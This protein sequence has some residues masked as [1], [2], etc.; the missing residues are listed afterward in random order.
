MTYKKIN[1]SHRKFLIFAFGGALGALINWSGTYYLT[2]IIHIYYVISNFIACVAAIIF[3]FTYHRFITFKVHDKIGKRFTKFVL[4]STFIIILNV[5]ITYILTSGIGLWYMYS[6]VLATCSVTIVNYILNS[7]YIFFEMNEIRYEERDMDFYDQQTVSKN[8]LRAWFHTSRYEILNSLVHRYY[9]PNKVIMDIGC[10][11]CVWNTDHLPVIGVDI[12]ENM[13]QHAKASGRLSEYKISEISSIDHDDDSVDIIVISEVLEH[14]PD[15]ERTIDEIHR[16]LKPGGI[17]ISSVPYDTLIS[18]WKPLFSIQCIIQ[19]Y[20]FGDDYYKNK[21]GHVQHFSPYIIRNAISAKGFEII[22]KINMKRFT[23]FTVASKI[24]I[25]KQ[26]DD[27][28]V[29]IPTLNESENISKLVDTIEKSYPKISI[30]VADDGS[31]DGTQQIV[32]QKHEQNAK[33]QLLDRSKKPHGLTASIVDAINNVNT[34]YSI[35]IDGDFQ[36]PPEKIRDISSSLKIGNDL[37]IGTRKKVENWGVFRHAISIGATKLGVISL[38]LRRS[39][40]CKDIMSGFFGVRTDLMKEYVEK[41]PS[42]FKG[43]GYKVLFDL[44][45]LLPTDV[46]LAEVPYVFRNREEGHS[47]INKKHMVVYFKSLFK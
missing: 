25:E 42:Y 33:I 11:S 14:L 31:I 35:V 29:I 24:D 47:K 12:N 43:E 13:L 27:T 18:F 8:P 6:A 36:H 10:G 22:E 41:N 21:C 37:A 15:F 5:S 38:R 44:L 2:D 30:I 45:K 34:K 4:V 39:A 23:I 1:V 26:Y 28:T 46:K 20:L 17:M 40:R 7:H 16:I 19:G 32:L 3:N 9:V